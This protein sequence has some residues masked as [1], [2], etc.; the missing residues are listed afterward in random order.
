MVIFFFTSLEISMETE[1]SK[2]NLGP[3]QEPKKT[4]GCGV[5]I[6]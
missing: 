2:F 1:L 3:T 4:I 5:E 6:N